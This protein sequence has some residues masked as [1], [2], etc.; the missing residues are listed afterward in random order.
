MPR[1]LT[2]RSKGISFAEIGSDE[3]AQAAIVALNGQDHMGE[4]I[5]VNE[6]KPRGPR[7]DGRGAYGRG[8][9]RY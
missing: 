8:R 5:V 3:E 9:D 1:P 4:T 6:A 7:G 2:G